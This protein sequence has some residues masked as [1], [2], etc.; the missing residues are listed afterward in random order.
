M[1]RQ[2]ILFR[3]FALKL[4]KCYCIVSD[5]VSVRKRKVQDEH[6]VKENEREREKATDIQGENEEYLLTFAFGLCAAIKFTF[7]K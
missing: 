1:H 7:G 3:L 4:R 6:K 2:R 5:E